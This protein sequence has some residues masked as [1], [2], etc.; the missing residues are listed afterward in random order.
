[1]SYHEI[2]MTAQVLTGEISMEE[3]GGGLNTVA[4]MYLDITIFNKEFQNGVRAIVGE[5]FDELLRVRAKQK[6]PFILEILR[7][8]MEVHAITNYVSFLANG[9]PLL[10][11]STEDFISIQDLSKLRR[12]AHL[13]SAKFASKEIHGIRRGSTAGHIASALLA[14]ISADEM[15]VTQ[16]DAEKCVDEY[17]GRNNSRLKESWEGFKALYEELNAI[18]S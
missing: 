5:R 7:R 12:K 1:M 2:E 8:D 6:A 13:R 3:D 15:G 14:G 11:I 9:L 10:G 17:F 4:S 18:F 16:A